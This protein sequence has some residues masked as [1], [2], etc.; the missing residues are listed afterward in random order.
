MIKSIGLNR[1]QRHNPAKQVIYVTLGGSLCVTVIHSLDAPC[2][3]PL[4]FFAI[5]AM[6]NFYDFVT[7][8]PF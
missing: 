3:S 1:G 6:M 8:V 5:R 4:F 7:V 2:V